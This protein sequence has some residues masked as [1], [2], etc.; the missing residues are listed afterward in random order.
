MEAKI[1]IRKGCPH[2]VAV[3]IANS[4]PALDPGHWVTRR[5]AAEALAVNPRTIDRYIRRGELSAYS[6][7][8]LDR[9][10]HQAG[11]GVRIWRD[12]VTGFHVATR[13]EVETR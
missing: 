8:V 4:T 9:S 5:Q 1:T 6:G 12:D 2:D 7:P 10:E 3:R 13:V 11:H